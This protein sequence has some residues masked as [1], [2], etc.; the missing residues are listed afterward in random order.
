[1]RGQ[2]ERAI[3][4][5]A[6]LAVQPNSL[7]RAA[8][9]GEALVKMQLTEAVLV[10]LRTAGSFMTPTEIESR[11]S[12]GDREESTKNNRGTLAYPLK[13]DRVSR[14]DRGNYM[15]ARQTVTQPTLAS[16]GRTIRT[17]PGRAA[18][19]LSALRCLAYQRPSGQARD[20]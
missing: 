16:C 10:V 11:L 2:V 18:E 13:K 6:G 12:E 5:L 8:H 7:R 15:A 17:T 9:S 1:M 4:R 20:T 19:M 14:S 3:A